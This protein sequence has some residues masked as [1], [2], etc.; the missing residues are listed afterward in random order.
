MSK[1]M[2]YF[3]V[4]W[5]L[6]FSIFEGYMVCIEKDI[7]I[8]APALIIQTNMFHYFMRELLEAKHGTGKV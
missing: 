1:K 3:F 5:T 4:V 2:L 6:S 8:H 7:Y